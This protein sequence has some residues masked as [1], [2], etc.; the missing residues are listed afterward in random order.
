VAKLIPSIGVVRK[1]GAQKINS[2]KSKV[3][4]KVN[5][6][7]IK[8]QAEAYSEVLAHNFIEY[9]NTKLKQDFPDLKDIQLRYSVK[10]IEK[11]RLFKALKRDKAIAFIVD[12]KPIGQVSTRD[13]FFMLEYG[14]KDEGL[15]PNSVLRKAFDSY[16]PIYRKTIRDEL[17]KPK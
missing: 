1:L 4:L 9:F 11:E 10:P 2:Y 7:T 16:K 5:P 14:R 17:T 8:P 6:K 12:E 13:L 3:K 15:L